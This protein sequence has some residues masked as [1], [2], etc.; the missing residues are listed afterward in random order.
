MNPPVPARNADASPPPDGAATGRSNEG[1]PISSGELLPTQDSQGNGLPAAPANILT[2]PGQAPLRL[3]EKDLGFVASLLQ[4]PWKRYRKGLKRCQRK[5]SPGAVHEFRIQIRRLLSSLELL[6]GLLP[7]RRV[8]KLQRLLKRRLDLFDDLRDTQVQL[9]T[10]AGMRKSFPAARLFGRSL[11]ERE[12][13][14]A[15]RARKEIKKVGARRVGQRIAECGQRLEERLQ[16]LS[17]GKASQALLRPVQRAFRRTCA[18]RAR[19]NPD[20][21]ATIHQ[22]RVAFKHFRYMVEALAPHLPAATKERLAAMRHYQ[23]MMGNIQDSEVLLA[24]LDKFLRKEPV[25]PEATRHFRQ[26]LLRHRQQLV[27]SYL[28]AA[29]K[30]FTFWPLPESES[31]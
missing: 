25:A 13:R 2:L 6:S 4:Q 14:F 1:A 8:E 10:L 12:E 7:A 16:T 15:G 28:G 23:T 26:H 22:T 24:A 29:D 5:F 18:L 3:P 17:A 19:I 21:T 31:H 30:L 20:D 9:Q 27:Q 11:R